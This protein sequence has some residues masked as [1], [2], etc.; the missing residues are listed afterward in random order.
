MI[1]KR[2]TFQ[3]YKFVIILN[4]YTSNISVLQKYRNTLNEFLNIIPDERVLYCDNKS[5]EVIKSV[6]PPSALNESKIIATVSLED[7]LN[8]DL[9]STTKKYP[10]IVL[11]CSENQNI[12]TQTTLIISLSIRGVYILCLNLESISIIEK[13]RKL[14]TAQNIK[15]LAMIGLD[16]N[17]ISHHVVGNITPSNITTFLSAKPKYVM[18][19]QPDFSMVSG[20]SD[21]AIEELIKPMSQFSSATNML[22]VIDFN[23]ELIKNMYVWSYDHI[24][25]KFVELNKE[26]LRNAKRD[27]YYEKIRHMNYA[28]VPKYLKR[29]L[30][31]LKAK[32]GESVAN[33]N[34]RAVRTSFVNTH[35]KFLTNISDMLGK[36]T[37]YKKSE[38]EN[39]ILMGNIIDNKQDI[40][41]QKEIDFLKLNSKEISVG[42]CTSMSAYSLRTKSLKNIIKA[43]INKH[44]Q[45][46][47]GKYV[48]Y[49]RNPYGINLE[50][51]AEIENWISNEGQSL[52]SEIVILVRRI[53]EI[54][55]TYTSYAFDDTKNKES[56]KPK[57]FHNDRPK[58]QELLTY[59]TLIEKI[60][61][62]EIETNKIFDKD[63][64]EIQSIK[65]NIIKTIK[66]EYEALQILPSDI[67]V[68]KLEKQR[69]L[70][71]LQDIA[72]NYR[73]TIDK[74][75]TNDNISKYNNML[76]EPYV[77]SDD[78]SLE[79]QQLL[80]D[81][82]QNHTD[83]IRQREQAT[84]ELL[85]EIEQ[86]NDIFIDCNLLIHNQ[87]EQ[88]D[89]IEMHMSN[90]DDFVQ[91][92][93][94]EL[95]GAREY[96]KKSSSN[97]KYIFGSLLG[98]G[99]ILGV[100]LG[101]KLHH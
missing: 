51:V 79:Q 37:I 70:I 61:Q 90:A 33:Y 35:L 50:E 8:L 44:K 94:I 100:I 9:I 5:F 38:L 26:V 52:Q 45:Y 88:L 6:F 56:Y 36:T 96:Q 101:T 85:K 2:K 95:N 87:R 25:H 82:V 68:V 28:D 77:D 13:F 24:L 53:Y 22:V 66:Q 32:T 34:T 72:K 93:V 99:G 55:R 83:E 65:I 18:K 67:Y 3:Y 30:A 97:A 14:E 80:D 7:N 89:T 86:L 4:M 15:Y 20:L 54:D 46:N 19:C 41:S 43:I 60:K 84:V 16:F 31:I 63:P 27:P 1:N 47:V 98:I 69:K 91:R 78:Y 11:L 76:D 21:S 75:N 59:H 64:D 17:P 92:G 12:I 42:E 23:D 49:V 81:S 29:E 74:M 40:L 73:K 39:R 58:K 57:I 10:G 71:E 62:L 48:I